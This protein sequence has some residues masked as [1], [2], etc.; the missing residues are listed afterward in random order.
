MVLSAG[1]TAVERRETM[2]ME[3]DDVVRMQTG[4]CLIKSAKGDMFQFHF[5]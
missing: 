3:D 1:G 5:D 4:D 2:A